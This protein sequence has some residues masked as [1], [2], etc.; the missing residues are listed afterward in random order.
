MLGWLV[1]WLIG[2]RTS[3]G[4]LALLQE[5]TFVHPI[6]PPSKPQNP[7]T[8]TSTHPLPLQQTTQSQTTTQITF[9]L[10]PTA[11]DVPDHEA[12]A[13]AV[14]DEMKGWEGGSRAPDHADYWTYKV[15]G[16]MRICI[17]VYV[18]VYV[19]VHVYT[20]V[21]AIAWCLRSLVH[22]C[23]LCVCARVWI[24]VDVPTYHPPTLPPTHPPTPNAL[25]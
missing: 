12:A 16:C 8:H 23:A 19:Y 18:Y 3:F 13:R 7:H 15:G 11:M 25:L 10:S 9:A 5:P 6:Q 17:D 4:S 22:P 2:L 1:S 21:Y 24:D 20:F 14:E